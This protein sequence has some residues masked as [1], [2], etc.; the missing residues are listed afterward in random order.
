MPY[1]ARKGLI[2]MPGTI[3][4][5]VNETLLDLG[6]LNPHFESAFGDRGVRKEWFAELLKQAFVTT[7]T[8]SYSNFGDIGRSALRVMETRHR[9]DLSEQQRSRILHAMQEL[10]PHADVI[11]GFESLRAAGWRL[12][13]LTN[14]TL[15]VAEAQLGNAGLRT[16]LDRVFSADSVQRLKPAKEPYQMVARELGLEPKSLMVAAAHAWD[17]AGASNAGCM[18]AFISRQGQVFDSLTPAPQF[19]A[20]DVPDLAKQVI[21]QEIN[22]SAYP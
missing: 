15:Q 1:N 20:A 17:I 3:A 11:A 10:P 14:S 9:N 16:Y 13:A 21:A 2:I 22:A 8:H 7:I 5:D 19:T 12:V 18:T 4:F 6:A